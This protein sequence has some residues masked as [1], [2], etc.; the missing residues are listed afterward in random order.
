MEAAETSSGGRLVRTYNWS[1]II[2]LLAHFYPGVF[3]GVRQE[4]TKLDHILHCLLRL[5][6]WHEVD[7]ALALGQH[8]HARQLISLLT[9]EREAHE[10]N[11]EWD[12]APEADIMD[13]NHDQLS[14]YIEGISEIMKLNPLAD[15]RK[16]GRPKLFETY[17][18]QDWSMIV[19]DAQIHGIPMP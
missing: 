9:A 13:L 18:E 16:V 10:R 11:I 1:V 2:P 6:R 15:T 12:V 5:E 4:L 19:R 17:W 14:M 3:S 7:A 8:D